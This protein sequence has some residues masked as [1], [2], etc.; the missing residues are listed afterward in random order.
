MA[1]RGPS[2]GG[3]PDSGARSARSEADSEGG[4]DGVGDFVTA[5]SARTASN[6]GYSDGCDTLPLPPTDRSLPDPVF[7]SDAL[8]EHGAFYSSRDGAQSERLTMPFVQS[9][10]VEGPIVTFPVG[11]STALP[12]AYSYTISVDAGS[13]SHV[14]ARR[15]VAAAYAGTTQEHASGWESSAAYT[16]DAYAAS[17]EAGYTEYTGEYPEGY[18]Y[19]GY[20]APEVEAQLEGAGGEPGVEDVRD[21]FSLARHGKADEVKAMFERGVPVNIRDSFGNTVLLIGCQNGLKR[22]A[23]L[24]L[25][26]GADINAAN[27]SLPLY[28]VV[29]MDC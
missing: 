5:R 26:K 4:D 23:K 10:A 15:S 13:S 2:R 17:A 7:H 29:H 14:A 1:D 22:I 19:E 6:A 12:T 3:E 28:C 11:G 21:V 20:V 8:D 25:R 27:V 24:A 16:D 9:P 18:G